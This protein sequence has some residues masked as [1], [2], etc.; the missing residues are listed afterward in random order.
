MPRPR[1]PIDAGRRFHSLTIIAELEPHQRPYGG[2]TLRHFAVRCDCGAERVVRLQNLLSGN[3]RSCGCK[4][5]RRAT[6]TAA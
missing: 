3:T 5:H 1:T 4:A 6:E 2:G